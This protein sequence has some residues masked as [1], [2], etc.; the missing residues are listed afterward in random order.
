MKRRVQGEPETVTEDPQDLEAVVG[1]EASGG[2]PFNTATFSRKR[3]NITVADA[4]VSD[5]VTP[6]LALS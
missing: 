4:V 6:S 5:A 1:Q 2:D 3:P